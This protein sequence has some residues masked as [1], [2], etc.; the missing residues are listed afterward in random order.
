MSSAIKYPND[1]TN[2]AG[3]IPVY[4]SSSPKAMP[5]QVLAGPIDRN[6]GPIPVYFVAGPGTAPIGNDQGNP[7]NAIP[8]VISDVANAM[9]VWD[10]GVAPL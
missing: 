2:P 9:P 10:V 7:N 1:R 4:I 3:A 5:I 8:V 6:S